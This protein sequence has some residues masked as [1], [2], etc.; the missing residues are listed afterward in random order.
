MARYRFHFFD[1]STMTRLDTLPMEQA[2]FTWEVSSAGTFT[3]VI[4]L[5]DAEAMPAARVIPATM[6]LRTKL[7]VERDSA[8]IWGG[9]VT[10]PGRMTPAPAS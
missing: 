1:W 8:L 3:G 6:P 5:R 2:T 9:Q 10:E 4:D 7:F